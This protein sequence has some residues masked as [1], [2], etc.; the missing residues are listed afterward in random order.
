MYCMYVHRHAYLP[1]HFWTGNN[2][3]I[4][5]GLM[6]SMNKL[7][8]KVLQAIRSNQC[9]TWGC[10][11]I[12]HSTLNNVYK[13]V[14]CFH[15]S[16]LWLSGPGPSGGWCPQPQVVGDVQQ[17]RRSAGWGPIRNRQ[18]GPVCRTSFQLTT[19]QLWPTQGGWPIH[20]TSIFVY[21]R[22]ATQRISSYVMF[23]QISL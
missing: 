9:R 14:V 12:S 4:H 10:G 17:V 21:D 20:N 7:L 2:L 1:Q 6:S 19:V 16:L 13:N 22:I 8:Y 18:E 23:W 5:K 11:W 15:L 3:I